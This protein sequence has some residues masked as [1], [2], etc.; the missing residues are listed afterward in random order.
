METEKQVSIY[1][2]VSLR[3]QVK[4]FVWVFYMCVCET[5]DLMLLSCLT[6]QR[7]LHDSHSEDRWQG[8]TPLRNALMHSQMWC[9]TQELPW[10]PLTYLSIQQWVMLSSSSPTKCLFVCLCLVCSVLRKSPVVSKSNLS[11]S[12][13]FLSH[14][15]HCPCCLLQFKLQLQTSTLKD[16]CIM[17]TFSHGN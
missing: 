10:H 2:L 5:T 14:T 6:W 3:E 16:I 17:K 4:Q 9:T 13:S 11:S 8:I 12:T 15:S 7:R 1:V